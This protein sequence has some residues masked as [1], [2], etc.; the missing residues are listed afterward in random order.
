MTIWRRVACWISKATRAHANVRAHAP[1]H[2]RAH[3]LTHVHAHP[4]SPPHT[5]T[6]KY[7]ILTAFHGNN[8]F[9]NPPQC[10]I[11]RTYRKLPPTE[12]PVGEDIKKRRKVLF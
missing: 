8:C 6:E 11:V 7:V 12:K 1:T 4:R 2:A 10:Y 5:H 9:L 3:A